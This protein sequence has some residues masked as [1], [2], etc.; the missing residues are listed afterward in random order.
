MVKTD[1]EGAELQKPREKRVLR[2]EEWA[3]PS[4]LQRRKESK[5]CIGFGH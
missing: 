1:L 3:T 5:M 2:R 4:S